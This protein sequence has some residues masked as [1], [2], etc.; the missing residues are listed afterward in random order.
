MKKI[1]RRLI[2]AALTSAV[3]LALLEL[4]LRAAGFR[5]L[6]VPPE[7]A[8]FWVYDPQLGWAHRPGQAGAFATPQFRTHVTIN[9]QGLR[10]REY[11][12]ERVPGKR[13]ILALG[14]SMTWG[15]GV[16][17]D[18]VFTERL[19]TLLPDTEVINA[20]VSG[21][22]TDQELL[23]LEGAGLR[24]KPDLVVVL[25]TGNDIP[26]NAESRVY[27]RYYKPVFKRAADGTLVLHNS[28]VPRL[29]FFMGAVYQLRVRSA[30]VHRLSFAVA[31]MRQRPAAV[32]LPPA[33]PPAPSGPEAAAS[34]PSAPAPR[35]DPRHD[36]TVRLLARMKE[37]C[38]GAGAEL[39]VMTVKEFWG[40]D[41]GSYA[42]FV[43]RLS[44]EGFHVID[45]N[46]LPGYER[47]RYVI[48]NE[49][50]W[51]PEGHDFVARRLTEQFRQKGLPGF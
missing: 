2:L 41:A 40:E 31:R 29:S 37:D 23:W 9:S 11:P 43:A 44:R 51:N 22:S 26:M 48:R 20:G 30:L 1:G 32:A 24:Y 36:L 33:P 8:Q 27:Y 38:R 19:E 35:Q 46:A 34:A 50:H 5:P 15:F 18:E 28:P 25:V 13:R 21:Y 12:V 3:S 39:C 47:E 14:D 16:E 17:Q 45:V 42:A 49:F 6:D 10:D 4:V 7:R